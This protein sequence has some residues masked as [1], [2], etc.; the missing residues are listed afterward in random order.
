MLTKLVVRYLTRQLRSDRGFWQAYQSNIAVI[1]QDNYNA[2]EK[3][4]K[5]KSKELH[6]FSNKCAKDFL[7]IWTRK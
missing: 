2:T 1:I 6:E 4:I 3:P 5:R 7:E